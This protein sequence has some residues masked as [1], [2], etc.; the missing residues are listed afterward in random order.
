MAS[1]QKQRTKGNKRPSSSGRAAELLAR[2][3]SSGATAS[4]FIGFGTMS[5]DLGYVP[6]A[7]SLSLESDQDSTLESDFRMAL[8]KLTKRDVVT[9]LKAIQEFGTLCKEK[10]ADAV[11]GTLPHWPRIYSRLAT[12]HD[13]RVREATQQAFEQLILRVRRNLAPQLRALMGC[14]LLSQCDTY[15]PAAL[16]ARAAFQSAFP[17]GK[18]G[19][20]VAFCKTEV[21]RYLEDNLFKETQ[22]SL[23]DPRS[24]TPEEQEERYTRL[25]T[26]SLL[27]LGE[28]ATLLPEKELPSVQDMLSSIVAEAKFWKLA[29]NKSPQL[30]N[31]MYSVLG[32]LIQN[33]PSIAEGELARVSTTLLGS[34]DESDPLAVQCLWES[35]LFVI[36]T[37]PNCWTHV[38]M[39]KA[40]LPKLWVMLRN[41]GSGSAT[42]IYPNL[43]PLLSHIPAEVIGTGVEFYQ[44]LFGNL[45]EGLGS[46]SA[47]HSSSEYG[48]LVK[49][50][51]ECLR[52]AISQTIIEGAVTDS[53]TVQNYLIQ[54]QL[55][56][57]IVQSIT[58]EGTHLAS[59]SLF[60]QTSKLLSHL[61]K[62]L[63]TKTSSA[64][65]ILEL[66]WASLGSVCSEHVSLADADATS[67]RSL[68]KISMLLTQ[69][70]SQEKLQKAKMTKKL[71]VSFSVDEGSGQCLPVEQKSK[72][73][74]RPTSA[75][76]PELMN[77]VRSLVRSSC[78]AAQG[79]S[80]VHLR[81]MERI[82]DTFQQ[83][84]VF[85][86]LLE[87]PENKDDVEP[88]TLEGV[89]V[90]ETKLT[91]E[92][93]ICKP[94]TESDQSYEGESSKLV[95]EAGTVLLRCFRQILL[96]WVQ[97]AETSS[98]ESK[99]DTVYHVTNIVETTLRCCEDDMSKR[100]MLDEL[101]KG[102]RRP[103]TLHH[104]IK[105]ILNTSHDPAITTWLKSPIFGEK[106]LEL[107]DQLCSQALDGKTDGSSSQ[108]WGLINLGLS[109]QHDEEPAVH[110]SYA[111]KILGKFT[112]TLLRS[113]VK[114]EG[115]EQRV[116]NCIS[117]ICDVATNFFSVVKG[118]LLITSAEDL[119]LALFQLGSKEAT[120]FPGLQQ[121]VLSAWTIGAE[122]LIK[123]T[124]GFLK[125]EGFLCKAAA[126]IKNCLAQG[127]HTIHSINL[128]AKP[129]VTL[130]D[131]IL[132]SLPTIMDPDAPGTDDE[133][134]PGSDSDSP[135]IA[136]SFLNLLVPTETEWNQSLN[137][138]NQWMAS[139]F[140]DETLTF[141]A[142]P[143][144]TQVDPIVMPTGL[145]QSAFV[146]ALLRRPERVNEGEL[147]E[148]T[149]TEGGAGVNQEESAGCFALA[150]LPWRYD[151]IA[152]LLA[153]ML[154]SLQWCKGTMGLNAVTRQIPVESL[155][156]AAPSYCSQVA[157]A[158]DSTL[159][160][161]WKS[162]T[163]E[164]WK[165][166][167]KDTLE[168]SLVDGRLWS[169]SLTY[170]LSCHS[171]HQGKHQELDVLQIA[172]G[173][174]RFSVLWLSAIH[175]LEAVIPYLSKEQTL[176]LLE[177]NTAKLMSAKEEMLVHVD[178]GLGSM[179][180]VT[181]ILRHP[182]TFDSVNHSSMMAGCINQLMQWRQDYV[183]SF[184]FG[185]DINEAVVLDD[186]FLNI[187]MMQ[188]MRLAIEK[189]PTAL[190]EQ[191]WDFL[192]C[193]IVAWIQ[194][195]SQ[196]IKFAQ[197]SPLVATFYCVTFDLLT[198]AA[199]LLG[200]RSGSVTLPSNLYTEW[201]E[202]YS[203][204]I[205]LLM[206]P[207][208][209]T[210]VERTDLNELTVYSH[211]LL[212][213]AADAVVSMPAEQVKKHTLTS[214]ALASGAKAKSR[215]KGQ[216]SADPNAAEGKMQILLERLCP[217]LI[218]TDR[219]AKLAAFQLL[220]KVMDE[221]ARADEEH[222]KD[223][224]DKD[225]REEESSIPPPEQLK[226]ILDSASAFMEAILTDVQVGE[227]LTLD[228]SSTGY[229]QSM[230][231]V[232][233]YLLV[234]R[235]YLKIFKSASAEVRAEYAN[236]LRL[237]GGVPT[238]M[239]NLFRLMPDPPVTSLVV[240]QSVKG[241]AP[242][243]M[244]GTTPV[245][246]AKDIFPSQE[247]IHHQACAL[248]STA[249][250]D[251]PAMV[252]Q[253][254][255]SQDKKIAPIVDRF[256]TKYASPLLCT[257]EVQDVQT[258]T[259]TFEN[260]TVKARSATREV[261]ATYTMQDL[262]MDLTVRI[263]ANHPLGIITVDSEKKVGVGT[264]QWRNWTL[265][266]STFLRNQNG[267]IMDG[268]TLWKRNVDKRFE[269]VEDCMI[270]FSVIHGSNCSLPKLQCKTCKKRYHSACLYKWFSTSNQ[271]TCPLC[272]SPF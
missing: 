152:P 119:L 123:Q 235:L 266:L 149:D 186:V 86:E 209:V 189:L 216:A 4:G 42:V 10:D 71:S 79:G 41:G 18:Q 244:F 31:A 49:A 202:F 174:D 120:Q 72:S 129:A 68:E 161:L 48:A 21:L 194:T 108:S 43:L 103:Q 93:D 156:V 196:S 80:I 145:V 167:V 239:M 197:P 141:T 208:F 195:C 22:A 184:L 269:G 88:Q 65:H 172:Q 76:H 136:E 187:K 111:E 168:M 182:D 51:M 19:E 11:K 243:S 28:F 207:M 163:G 219:S 210:I 246:K 255:T 140:L 213:S 54:D 98:S 148:V 160:S 260:M 181:A 225:K 252:R 183:D 121:K 135:S 67:C 95:S 268:L 247:E 97:S 230:S 105:K 250:E 267:S 257:Q 242:R 91:P 218:K 70:V 107:S 236:Y 241:S 94:E 205:F 124:G 99:N 224:D 126:W 238:L 200:N 151:V 38:N 47:R 217:M 199:T 221:I 55:M 232:L 249:L 155:L 56:L 166:L 153:R 112:A 44:E 33:T 6:A 32:S 46:P 171:R 144:L 226:N 109:V 139:L 9:K 259:Q 248:Y 178:G 66:F 113:K 177:I 265:Q 150:P 85:A 26:C 198:S 101:C 5:G 52:Y 254:W 34:L 62:Q 261:I 137:M 237:T 116:H 271:S 206:L 128:L 228:P 132:R 133:D 134:T 96:P 190:S 87:L 92:M 176:Q 2:D 125:D 170:L 193:S 175:T 69:L 142:L 8:R 251:L 63:S 102:T 3:G 27:A 78:S 61:R 143:E 57:F 154:Y 185:C 114:V 74:Q 24:F 173:M 262:S 117:F 59:T 253:W 203:D 118:C 15:A 82:F 1:K 164:N 272:R 53:Q 191:H 215:V 73:A 12:D 25:L 270:C 100:T 159:E 192:L 240:D 60:V 256:T 75:D 138:P 212:Q 106:L 131:I 231:S 115:N 90:V 20:A 227:C 83:P 263:P 180:V 7:Q 220:E 245:M 13:K 104:L 158:I 58:E 30:R 39:R 162:L 81:F 122:S 64:R 233:T 222:L 40:V 16:S 89:N 264:T 201:R 157:M 36:S 179:S 223:N 45:K 146:A 110:A 17:Q 214:K 234:W 165:A 23:S 14:W 169:S 204:G 258:A 84:E 188:L 50:Y 130:C 211:C 35:V 127:P 29:K 37:F 229:Y 147:K 77:L